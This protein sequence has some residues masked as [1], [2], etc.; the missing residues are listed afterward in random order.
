[1]SNQTTMPKVKVRGKHDVQPKERVLVRVEVTL[2][3][4]DTGSVDG[5]AFVAIWGDP[6]SADNEPRHESLC[7]YM[8]S[9]LTQIAFHVWNARY[10]LRDGGR[11]IEATLETRP[12]LG[13]QVY[14]NKSRSRE[15]GG[16]HV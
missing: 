13:V 2:T 5:S 15:A 9:A 4:P 7:Y 11:E 14:S 1:M 12:T 6:E 3:E 8:E 16:N 10:E